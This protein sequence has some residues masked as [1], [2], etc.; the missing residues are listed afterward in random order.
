V[1]QIVDPELDLRSQAGL[2]AKLQEQKAAA[3][4]ELDLLIK[5]GRDNDPRIEQARRR[6]E[7]IDAR[8]SQERLKLGGSGQLPQEGD[9]G[10]ADI[11]GE[12]ERLVVDREFA[13][14]AYISARAAH[15]SALS[16]ARRKSRYLAA[17][18]EPTEAQSAAYPERL[19][20][21][22]VITLFLFLLWSIA[23]LI[24]YSVKDRR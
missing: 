13:Q 18:M 22:I 9:R 16:E 14:E 19:T 11:I 8:I 23:V 3:L 24:Y 1:N 4:I 10:F 21:Q 12:Y 2:L 7:V 20:L 5:T 15:D 17:Y 6:L